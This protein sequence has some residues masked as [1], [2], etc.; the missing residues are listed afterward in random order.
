MKQPQNSF[1]V[2]EG[3]VFF[4]EESRFEP[5]ARDAYAVWQTRTGDN[6]PW[7]HLAPRFRAAWID[8]ARA[9]AGDLGVRIRKRPRSGPSAY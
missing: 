1:G 9:F 5:A 6:T 4:P 8:V 7:E 3:N 2:M